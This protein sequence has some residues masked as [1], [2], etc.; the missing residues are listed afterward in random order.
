MRIF[1]AY[2]AAESA[3]KRFV[4]RSI[5]SAHDVDDICQETVARALEAERSRKIEQPNAFLFGIAR[6]VIRKRLDKQSRSV[7]EFVDDFSSRE[8][9]AQGATAEETLDARQQKLLL[10]EA[11]ATLPPQCQRVFVMKKLYGYT[12]KEIA[13]SLGISISTVEK[14]IAAGFRRCMDEMDKPQ[15]EIETSDESGGPSDRPAVRQKSMEN[16]TRSVDK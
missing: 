2:I 16:H 9:F 6:N 12:H 10:M 1:N 5:S 15:F 11:V 7:I 4:Q 3:L 8:Y 13:V 14:H